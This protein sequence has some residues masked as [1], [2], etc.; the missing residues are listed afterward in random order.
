MKIDVAYGR[1][2]DDSTLEQLQY[3]EADAYAFYFLS[4]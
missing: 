3:L 4:S 1:D 2:I